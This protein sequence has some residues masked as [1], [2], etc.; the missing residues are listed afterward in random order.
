MQNQ[1]ETAWK[2][3]D[4]LWD[5]LTEMYPECAQFSANDKEEVWQKFYGIGNKILLLREQRKSVI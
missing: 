3:A 5:N 1:N 4:K 2:M